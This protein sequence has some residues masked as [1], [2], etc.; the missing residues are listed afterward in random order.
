VP[1]SQALG[2]LAL[3]STQGSQVNVPQLIS[4]GKFYYLLPHGFDAGVLLYYGSYR[5]FTNPNLNGILRSYS[6]YFGR[7]W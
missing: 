3:G 1:F 2:A 4:Q 6:F 5:D 7:A